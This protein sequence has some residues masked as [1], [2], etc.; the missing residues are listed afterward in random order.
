MQARCGTFTSPQFL[1][2][3]LIFS[4]I[5][6]P[7][8]KK[9]GQENKYVLTFGYTI[10][11]KKLPTLRENFPQ[12]PSKIFFSNVD[13]STSEVFY[14]FFWPKKEEKTRCLWAV[15]FSLVQR[16]NIFR[17][18]PNRFNI[19]QHSSN[20]NLQRFAAD[21]GSRVLYYEVSKEGLVSIEATEE[22]T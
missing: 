13:F 20:V 19:S 21:G 18:N 16:Y 1:S 15:S 8:P 14:P 9:C 17:R 6:S 5:I 22:A 3:P 11:A 12:T 7:P 2:P 4:F 10:S